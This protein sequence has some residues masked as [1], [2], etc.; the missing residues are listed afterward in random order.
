MITVNIWYPINTAL[1]SP[2]TLVA[3][4]LT[5]LSYQDYD[6]HGQPFD[7]RILPDF[8][9]VIRPG[10]LMRW[11]H[12][13]IEF[14]NVTSNSGERYPDAYRAF[15][16]QT[17]VNWRVAHTGRIVEDLNEDVRGE[18]SSPSRTIVMRGG[19]NEAACYEYWLSMAR[20]LPDYSVFGFNCCGAVA[21]SIQAGLPTV[22][23]GRPPVYPPLS[24]AGGWLPIGY[25]S[26]PYACED[27]A[28]TI[29]QWL[30][31]HSR[32]IVDPPPVVSHG[33]HD[34]S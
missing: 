6:Y 2:M 33:H 25:S 14:V 16:P 4:A 22:S 19:L 10:D 32:P 1:E 20:N 9:D 21:A 23:R 24:S 17:N 11:G 28:L 13:G 18:E 31:V 3:D 12:A 15:W 30:Q 34:R 29:N 27:W 5:D 26:N 7:H 8:I